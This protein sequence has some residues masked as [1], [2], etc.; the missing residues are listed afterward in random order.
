MFVHVRD[1][2]DVLEVGAWPLFGELTSA[3]ARAEASIVFRRCFQGHITLFSRH[4]WFFG[5]SRVRTWIFEI[6]FGVMGARAK[7]LY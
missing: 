7:P 6:F 3:H 1:V 2:S 4:F 5:N